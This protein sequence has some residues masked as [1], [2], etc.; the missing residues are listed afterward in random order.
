MNIKKFLIELLDIFVEIYKKLEISNENVELLY[1]NTGVIIKGM[2][3]DSFNTNLFNKSIRPFDRLEDNRE[4]SYILK[5][6]KNEIYFKGDKLG[7]YFA[8]YLYINGLVSDYKFA[9]NF[10]RL[11]ESIDK[12]DLYNFEIIEFDNIFK[13]TENYNL[14]DYLFKKDNVGFSLKDLDKSFKVLLDNLN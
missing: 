12:D 1:L 4:R 6:F 3:N 14:Y 7:L 11:Y 8:I 2:L 5:T 10:K 13:K 9:K